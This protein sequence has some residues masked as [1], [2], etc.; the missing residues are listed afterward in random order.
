MNS[1]P[2]QVG[3]RFLDLNNDEIFEIKQMEE[4]IMYQFK[5][6]SM[7]VYSYFLQGSQGNEHELD[8]FELINLII[9]D[10]LIEEL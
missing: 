10:T 7:K 9:N 5:A 1:I 8:H 3:D 4:C 6:P 2:F